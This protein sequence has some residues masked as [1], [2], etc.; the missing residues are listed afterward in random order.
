MSLEF[1][2]LTMGSEY[3]NRCIVMLLL[4][5]WNCTLFLVAWRPTYM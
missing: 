2:T 5:K 4:I 1:I 3:G